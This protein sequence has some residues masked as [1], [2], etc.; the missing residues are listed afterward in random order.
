MIVAWDEKVNSDFEHSSSMSSGLAKL[1][2]QEAELR[3]MLPL[4]LG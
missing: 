2:L 1:S 4:G 3:L